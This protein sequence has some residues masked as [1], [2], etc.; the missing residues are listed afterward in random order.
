MEKKIQQFTELLGKEVMLDEPLAKYTTFK[1]GGPAK[2]FF[3]AKNIEDLV[4]AIVYTKKVKLAF[5]VL[6]GGSN[7]LVSDDGFNGLVIVNQ[8]R[9]I[10]FKKD[11]NVVVD[12]GTI[13][14]DLV[15]KTIDNGL[16]GLEW[17]AGIP[18]TV[19]GA[20]RGNAG[21][22]GGQMADNIIGV[23]VMRGGKQFIIAK[24]KL[25][26]NYRD[27]IFKHNNDLLISGEFQ[28]KSGN[29]EK[30]QVKVKEIL[31]ERK[32]KQPLEFPSA[33][34]IFTNLL[35]NSENQD[36]VAKLRNLP[37]EYL[38]YKKI[39]AAWLIESLDLKSYKIGGAQI[40]DKHANFIVNVGNATANEVLQLISYVKMKVRDE[41]GL[42]LLEE[43]EY[44][45]F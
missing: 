2:A 11:F 31:A 42:Q 41:L 7:V 3:I 13:L 29:K 17:A 43:I 25:E 23:E 27:S 21:A 16:T 14:M 26:F 19:G 1:I 39:P 32:A 20:I 35:V 34:C 6:G 12:S 22:Y 15:N 44:V 8:A 30:S 37:T 36:R 40:S 45:G 9:D 38:A 4:R 33:G 5:Y 24:D 28:L 10:L 18:G